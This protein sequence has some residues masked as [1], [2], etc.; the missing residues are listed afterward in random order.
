MTTG[1]AFRTLRP[2]ENVIFQRAGDVSDDE[3]L[4]LFA[5]HRE[6]QREGPDI[7]ALTAI[8]GY[9]AQIP[10]GDEYICL[11]RRQALLRHEVV[12]SR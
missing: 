9:K 5:E 3:L 6:K 10:A 11:R 4:E 12:G 2:W 1:M 7:E 8:G